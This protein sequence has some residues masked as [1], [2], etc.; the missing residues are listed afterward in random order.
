ME[1]KVSKLVSYSHF[2]Y[3]TNKT[4]NEVEYFFLLE[5][6]EELADFASEA[7]GGCIVDTPDTEPFHVSQSD[8]LTFFGI[9]IWRPSYHTPR[10]VIQVN[11]E[12]I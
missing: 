11:I 1:E 8:Q 3:F 12:M 5:I 2:E 4:I 7:V 10:K 6:N 9:P